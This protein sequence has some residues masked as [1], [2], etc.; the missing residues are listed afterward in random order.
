MCDFGI[1]EPWF[2]TLEDTVI[3]QHLQ[4]SL[5][6]MLFLDLLDDIVI[7]IVVFLLG[8]ILKPSLSHSEAWLLDD[9]V[10]IFLLFL[11]NF[12]GNVTVDKVVAAYCRSVLGLVDEFSIDFRL[13]GCT[14]LFLLDNWLRI[15]RAGSRSLLFLRLF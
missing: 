14:H 2:F 5:L 7:I 8:V 12:G 1:F 15:V 9:Q 6:S 10:W 3:L 11:Y 4:L 13:K